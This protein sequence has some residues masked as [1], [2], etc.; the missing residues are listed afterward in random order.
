MG[1]LC[2]LPYGRKIICCNGANRSYCCRRHY[3][4]ACQYT[5]IALIKMISTH[6]IMFVVIFLLPI[7]EITFLCRL[8]G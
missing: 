2:F 7:L 6:S 5:A 4:K 3:D 1:S 8:E